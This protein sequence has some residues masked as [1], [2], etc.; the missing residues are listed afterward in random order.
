M[1]RPRAL[2]LDTL[3]VDRGLCADEREAQG[4]IMAGKVRVGNRYE[5]KA[6][7]RFPLDAPLEVRGIGQRYVSRGGLKLEAALARFQVRVEGCTALDAG[8]STGGFTDCLL[9]HGAARVYA[10]D[11]GHGQLRGK[12]SS[13][14]RVVSL[15]RTNISDLERGELDPLPGLA[16]ADLSYLSLRVAIPILARLLAEPPTL[17]CLIKPLF[18]G[19]PEQQKASPRSLPEVFAGIGEACTASGLGLVDLAPSPLRGRS[20]S[21]E[22]LAHAEPDSGSGPSLDDLVARALREADEQRGTQVGS[23]AR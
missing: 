22:F 10:V 7:K 5:T 20:N 4:W 18:E 17:V 3:L 9:Q 1:K 12:L 8:A 13:D 23:D 6:G 11:V 15:E 19:V 2:R 14:P 21:L 16:V